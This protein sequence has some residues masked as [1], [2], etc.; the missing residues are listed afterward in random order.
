MFSDLLS[1]AAHGVA[2]RKILDNPRLVV[3]ARATLERWIA[4][5]TPAPQALLE[6]RRIL[7]GTP[8][9]IA[10][11]ALSLTCEATRLR[12]SS[13]LTG[14]LTKAEKAAIHASLGRPSKKRA[15]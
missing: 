13:L 8:Q 11:V 6:W 4:K 1:A 7:A 10:A 2:A 5:Q 9:E 3:R 12:S 15:K 14:L